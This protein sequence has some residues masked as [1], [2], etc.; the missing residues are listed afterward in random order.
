MKSIRSIA[1]VGLLVGSCAA[2]WW[3][4]APSSLPQPA[5]SSADAPDTQRCS[6]CH[7]EQTEH[8][9]MTGHAR[10]LTEA[11]NRELRERFAGPAFA[12]Q[13]RYETREDRLWSAATQ[14]VP[15]IPVDWVFGSGRHAQTPV[16]LRHNADSEIKLLQHHVSW[17]PGHGLDWTLGSG[18]LPTTAV[19]IDLVGLRLDPAAT[20]ECFS[21]HCTVVPEPAGKFHLSGL[22]P[23]IS[24]ERCHPGSLTHAT[25]QLRGQSPSTQAQPAQARDRD[26]LSSINRCGEC[27]RRADH[28]S[29]DELQPSNQRLVRFAPVGLAMSRCF[30][31]QGQVLDAAGQRVRLDCRTCHD[32]HRPAAADSPETSR[33]CAVCHG[34]HLNAARNCSDKRTHSLCIDCHMPQIELQ[35]HLRFTDHWLRSKSRD[36]GTGLP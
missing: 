29:A 5:L 23:G 33:Q 17:Y 10:T 14:Q 11:T 20:R 26:P 30:Q 15:A 36:G 21:C 3:L 4:S 16:S 28:F 8:F 25:A 12:D 6:E 2:I 7:R 13:R 19:G 1:C 31:E 18:V 24:C 32:P 35:P 27:H 22:V 9:A 34:S